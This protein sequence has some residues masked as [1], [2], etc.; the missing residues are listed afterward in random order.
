MKAD[1]KWAMARDMRDIC[2]YFGSTSTPSTSAISLSNTSVL[3]LK[4]LS[5]SGTEKTEQY[6]FDYFALL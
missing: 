4:K 2:S 1:I 5:I 6:L 3:T